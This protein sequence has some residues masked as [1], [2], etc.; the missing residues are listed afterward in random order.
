MQLAVIFGGTAA[1]A[2]AEFEKNCHQQRLV[3]LQKDMFF[4]LVG[5]RGM[6][7]HITGFVY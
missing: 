3:L 4:Y 7:A 6:E 1:V 2:Q 5:A